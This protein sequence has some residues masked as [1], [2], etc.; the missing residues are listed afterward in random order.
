MSREI[1]GPDSLLH[2]SRR[3]TWIMTF[4]YAGFLFEGTD[5]DESA[6]RD[7]SKRR[8]TGRSSVQKSLKARQVVAASAYLAAVASLLFGVTHHLL[9]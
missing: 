2:D 1:C 9:L 3:N 4:P 6:D 7:D 8:T 5:R